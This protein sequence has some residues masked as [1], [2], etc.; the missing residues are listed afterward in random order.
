MTKKALIV[1]AQ[2]FEEIEAVTPIDILRRA[3]IDV[4]IAGIQPEKNSV[5]GAHG[6]GI[7]VDS[8]LENV[9]A[10]F[11]V[12]IFPGGMPGA[13]NLADSELVHSLISVMHRENRLIAAICAAPAVLLAPT[14]ILDGKTATCFPGMEHHFSQQTAFSQDPVVV[15]GNIITS[16]GAGTALTFSLK[17]VETLLNKQTAD[18]L[19]RKVLAG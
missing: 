4:H 16:R 6:I 5:T 7:T 14:G 18:D 8:P 9:Q 11:D 2:G 3:G 10:D 19:R 12:C 15:S 17:I 1:L 13:Q